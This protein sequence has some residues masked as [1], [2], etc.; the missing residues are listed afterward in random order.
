AAG[1]GARGRVRAGAALVARGEFSIII[2]GLAAPALGPEGVVLTAL[3][4]CYVLILAVVGPLLM[5]AA[6]P[7]ADRIL[8]QEPP[9]SPAPA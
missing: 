2:A 4:A 6:D 1:V 9:R 7:V 5:R 3:A 8:R